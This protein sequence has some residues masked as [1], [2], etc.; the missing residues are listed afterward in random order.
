MHA[1]EATAIAHAIGDPDDLVLALRTHADTLVLLDRPAE[2]LPLLDRALAHA[3]TLRNTDSHRAVLVR[4]LDCAITLG[5]LEL[6][7]S[8]YARA[9]EV[10]DAV[11]NAHG[12][13]WLLIH[14]SRLRRARGDIPAA[15]A[16]AR[17]ALRRMVEAGDPRGVFIANL[18]LAEALLSGGDAPGAAAL[19]QTLLS[20]SD[21]ASV[22]LLRAKAEALLGQAIPS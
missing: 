14:H 10:T 2:A 12:V 9:R 17:E 4:K 6:A 3:R 16:D 19:L 1:E 15:M 20:T 8:T 21:V 7:D 18:R 5:K 13:G 22:P 11:N